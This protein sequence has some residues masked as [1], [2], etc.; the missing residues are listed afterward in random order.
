MHHRR[1]CCPST[2]WLC[3][4]W[5]WCCR[6][7][8]QGERKFNLHV[9]R[10]LWSHG[11]RSSSWYRQIKSPS[12]TGEWDDACE[13][14]GE[15]CVCVVR[16]RNNGARIREAVG[17]WTGKRCSGS[18]I[19]KRLPRMYGRGS[20]RNLS[21]P[22][23]TKPKAIGITI[24]PSSPESIEVS[25]RKGVSQSPTSCPFH[26]IT[27]RTWSMPFSRQ[28]SSRIQSRIV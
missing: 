26:L 4:A 9:R 28:C 13:K 11:R 7:C 2:R 14:V 22:R 25:Y 6:R 23:I 1:C 27:S 24:S 17:V 3:C 15:R 10:G 12:G 20:G 5:R 16:H 19:L 8:G 18:R 21:K